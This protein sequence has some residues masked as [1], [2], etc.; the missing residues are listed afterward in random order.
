MSSHSCQDSHLLKHWR[1]THS[2]DV[3]SAILISGSDLLRAT[4]PLKVCSAILISGSH[5]L[6]HWRATH[7]LDVCSAIFCQWF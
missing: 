7:M 4:H 3:C 5:L 6:K 1:A 2:L